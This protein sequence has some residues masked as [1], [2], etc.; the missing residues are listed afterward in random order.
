MK[1][2]ERNGNKRIFL[3]LF[4]SLMYA[5]LG[6]YN[7]VHVL[8]VHKYVAHTHTYTPTQTKTLKNTQARIH[9]QHKDITYIE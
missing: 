8:F 2:Y 1:F 5:Y 4:V 7:C 9:T 6:L 3:I